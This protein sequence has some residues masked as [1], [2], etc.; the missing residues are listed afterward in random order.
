MTEA[1]RHAVRA[2]RV[3]D[4]ECWHNDAA[5]VIEAGVISWLG[6]AA[7]LPADT[8]CHMIDDGVL[9]PGFIDVQVN[10]GGGVL[11]NA[12]PTLDTL[13]TMVDAHR[14]S[15]TTAMLPTVISDTPE[16]QHAAGEAVLA[17][18]A[19]G[20]NAIL[21]IHIEGPFFAPERRGVHDQRHLRSPRSADIAWLKALAGR[22]TTVVTLAPEVVGTD[23]ITELA[24]AG[25]LVCAGHTNASVEQVDAALAAGLRGFTH[26]YNAM[27]P[28]AARAPGPVAAALTDSSSYVG[29]IADGHHVHP[30]ALGLAV[31][32]RGADHVM[33]VTDA[34][35]TMGTT[36]KSFRLYDQTVTETDG[37]LVTGDGV[38]AGSAI[39]MSDAVR[40]V[41]R[42]VGA[43][44]G[45][46]LRMAARTP[47]AFLG[48]GEQLGSIA[49]GYRA[50]LVALDSNLMVTCTW[51]AGE[52]R[53]Y[54]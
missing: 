25:V 48:L 24:S 10:G 27:P 3:F 45:D 36:E 39:G 11:L 7:D 37:R 53:R 13:R 16:I 32:A 51:V 9:A 28:I 18:L 50:D 4:G 31:S 41:Y 20:V 35:A 12:A 17:A 26:L 43:S 34:M 49:P 46:A 6:P 14:A 1:H 19:A 44:L 40:Y 8:P 21:G 42:Q 38:L 23:T 33:L 54:A 30:R 2:P 5:V 47:A 22:C 29:L 15:G 52:A